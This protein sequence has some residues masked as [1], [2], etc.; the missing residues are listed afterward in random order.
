MKQNDHFLLQI[1]SITLIYSVDSQT[2]LPTMDLYSEIKSVELE[3]E[4]K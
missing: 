2:D 4:R 1:H 3:V